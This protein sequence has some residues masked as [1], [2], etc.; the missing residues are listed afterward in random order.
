MSCRE[1]GYRWKAKTPS[2]FKKIIKISL[3]ISAT[4]LAIHTALV[5]GGA[6][7]PYW[8]S[9]IYPY[10]IGVPAGAAALSKFTMEDKSDENN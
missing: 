10:L 7:E 5:S 4:A 3:A 1:W 2:F 8:W 6:I 9:I